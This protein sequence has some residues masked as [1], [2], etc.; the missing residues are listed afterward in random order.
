MKDTTVLTWLI[1]A[2]LLTSVLF[3]F[4]LYNKKVVAEVPEIPAPAI[5]EQDKADIVNGVIASIPAIESSDDSDLYR[6]TKQEYEDEAIEAEAER[7]ALAELDTKDFKKAVFEALD[8]EGVD[9]ES[10]KDI[11]DFKIMDSDVDDN[12]V[13]FDIKVYYFLDGD[14]DE[15]EKARL[16]EFT[17]EIDDLYYE[18]NL[19]EGEVLFED[20]EVNEDYLNDIEIR[21]VYD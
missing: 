1:V 6:L 4:A 11:T 19:D 2:C 15:T 5:T 20:A 9:I 10:Y 16:E 17:I 7:L 18:E 13:T 21:K 8:D 14:E 12:E 3:G